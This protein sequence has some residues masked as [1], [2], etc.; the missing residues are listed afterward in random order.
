MRSLGAASAVR[1]LEIT[2]ETDSIDQIDHSSDNE[3]FHGFS[4][5]EMEVS[6]RQVRRFREALVVDG[7]DI[8]LDYVNIMCGLTLTNQRQQPCC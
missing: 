7:L 8:A 6:E 1:Y 4:A 5:E 2:S 3:E